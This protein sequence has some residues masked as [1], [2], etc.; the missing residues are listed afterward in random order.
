M[1]YYPFY[2]LK[3]TLM[4]SCFSVIGQDCIVFV[5]DFAI[6]K[7]PSSNGKKYYISSPASQGK[8]LQWTSMVYLKKMY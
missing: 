2:T 4:N 6:N 5:D 8:T 1:K 3:K 7:V